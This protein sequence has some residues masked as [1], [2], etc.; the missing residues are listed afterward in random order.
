MGLPCKFCLPCSGVKREID[1][2]KSVSPSVYVDFGDVSASNDCGQVGSVYDSVRI[3]FAPGELST[4]GYVSEAPPQSF[5]FGDLPCVP[6]SIHGDLPSNADG[7]GDPQGAFIPKLAVPAKLLAYDPAWSSCVLD[8]YHGY[9]PPRAMTP[10]AVPATSTRSQDSHPIYSSALPGSSVSST[11]YPTPNIQPVVSSTASK[12]LSS[13]A[14]SSYSGG[15]PSGQAAETILADPDPVVQSPPVPTD[16][17]IHTDIAAPHSLFTATEGFPSFLLTATAALASS[18]WSS[19]HDPKTSSGEPGIDPGDPARPSDSSST[20]ISPSDPPPTSDTSP[21]SIE[22]SLDPQTQV[23]TSQLFTIPGTAKPTGFSIS[24]MTLSVD[25]PGVTISGTVISL[26]TS[27]NLVIGSSTYPLTSAGTG[28]D[29]DSGA[30]LT[31]GG[32]TLTAAPWAPTYT[33]GTHVGSD[34][35]MF[36]IGGTMVNLLPSTS[37]IPLTIDGQVV[38]PENDSI[39]V[40]GA[41]LHESG[42]GTIISGTSVSVAPSGL[43]IGSRTIPLTFPTSIFTIGSDIITANPSGF[44]FG[45]GSTIIP[46]SPAMTINDTTISLAPSGT[47]IIGTRT[48]PLMMSKTQGLGAAIMSGFGEIGPS[49]SISVGTPESFKGGQPKATVPNTVFLIAGFVLMLRFNSI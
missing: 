25:E 10:V 13:S 34:S 8:V 29:T 28:F 19:S 39:N 38:T 17:G 11:G 31:M 36:I 40:A 3:V 21:T 44:E 12:T 41:S 18:P 47:L 20:S 14:W 35:S 24:G 5:N 27:E 26:A 46:G 2:L 7:Y 6:F 15:K 33:S 4:S 9:D 48:V 30:V 42:P 23:Q 32:Q 22:D 1:Y 16:L 43:I 37:V 49:T 45:S